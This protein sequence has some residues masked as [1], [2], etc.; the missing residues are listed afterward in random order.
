MLANLTLTG[1]ATIHTETANSKAKFNGELNGKVRTFDFGG[2]TLI[3]TGPGTVTFEK[4]T[5]AN[6]A[7]G[8]ITQ[9]G[10]TLDLVDVGEVPTSDYNLKVY[11]TT[12]RVK[13]VI[14]TSPG[15]GYTQANTTCKIAS[16][17]FQKQA[18]RQANAIACTVT[19]GTVRGGGL[20]VIGAGNKQRLN[21]SGRNT[22]AGVTTL[23]NASVKF[24]GAAAHPDKGGLDIGKGSEVKLTADIVAGSLAGQGEITGNFSVTG[25]TNLVVDAAALFG[26]D[27]T[28]LSVAGSVALAAN[29][30]VTVTGLRDLIDEAGD[31]N[32]F[33][34][35]M[36]SRNLLM[37]ANGLTADALT[38]ELPGLTDKE[39]AMFR[40]SVVGGAVRLGR[41][42][43]LAIFL[44]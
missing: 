41:N 27:Y 35:T 19:V 11:S 32:A 24:D 38:L 17:S 40:V 21:L 3:K 10:G 20:R 36:R 18:E 14:V 7:A 30:K 31:V 34:T 5:F 25:V 15:F 42:L 2:H 33:I 43:G 28:P 44:Q 13:G 26:D 6:T 37:S 8:G 39:A 29:A 23:E 1:N 22:Y 4:G 16:S 12:C 9:T